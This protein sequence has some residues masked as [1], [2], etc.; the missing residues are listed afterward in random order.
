MKKLLSATLF[1]ALFSVIGGILFFGDVFSSF[2][3]PF[4]LACLT[5]FAMTT[6]FL[7]LWL[8]FR[9]AAEALP[10]NPGETV[11][12]AT[13]ASQD[14]PGKRGYE[15]FQRIESYMEDKRPYLDEKLNL[16]S[17]SK[18]VFSNK[19]YVSKNINH[20]S[21]KNFRQFINWYRIQY[22][23]D[24]MKKDPHLRMEEVAMMSGFHTTVSFNMA[25]RLFVAKTPTEWHEEYVDSL[26]KG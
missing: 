6:T 13:P 1:C 16:D 3:F 18:A 26:R 24:L 11:T 12:S 15:L 5:F 4:R 9:Q 23:L 14:E 8:V 21:G 22:A 19:V 17:F 2:S 10:D 25:F 7:T 20:Y